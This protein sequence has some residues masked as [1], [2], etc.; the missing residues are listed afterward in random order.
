ML[1]NQ[2]PDTDKIVPSL[3]IVSGVRGDKNTSSWAEMDQKH[4]S[5][6]PLTPMGVLAICVPMNAD[7]VTSRQSNQNFAE[8]IQNI[9]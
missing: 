6:I 7:P 4:T 3:E 5:I 8:L 9:C 1:Y 2:G